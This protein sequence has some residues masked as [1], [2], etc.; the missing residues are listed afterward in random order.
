[1]VAV[2]LV[3][4]AIMAQN[5]FRSYFLFCFVFSLFFFFLSLSLMLHGPASHHDLGTWFFLKFR[6]RAVLFLSDLSQWK[7]DARSCAELSVVPSS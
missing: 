7:Q 6:L 3:N 5:H 1:M 2:V 4:T